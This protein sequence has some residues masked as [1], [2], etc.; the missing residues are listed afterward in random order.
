M[1]I[2]LVTGCAG[3]IGRT[4]VEQLLARGDYVVGVDSLTYAA[5]HDLLPTIPRFKLI[6]QDIREIDHLQ[7]ADVIFHLAGDTHVC[8]SVE[9][10]QRFIQTNILGTHRLLERIRQTAVHNR[11]TLIHVSTDEVYG[12]IES[13]F[14]SY[15]GDQTKPNSPYSA[16]KAAADQLVNAWQRTYDLK[17]RI[18]RPS[19]CYGVGQYPE[20]LIPKTIRYWQLGRRMTVHGDGTQ[21]RSWLAVEDCARAMIAVWLKGEDGG[22][23]NVPGN[24]EVSVRSVVEKIQQAC[25]GRFP[26]TWPKGAVQWGCERPGGDLRYQVDGGRLYQLGWKA[27]GDLNGDLEEIVRAEMEYGIA[28]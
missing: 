11:P 22:I 10:S 4:L 17:A 9:D 24:A 1:A 27:K 2:A 20:K 26:M 12:D 5:R 25:Q 16:S 7:H 6:V 3:F 14:L 21:V 28:V 8:N 19:N 23:Y 13:P 18:V 15:E